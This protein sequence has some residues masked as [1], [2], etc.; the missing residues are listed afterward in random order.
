MAGKLSMVKDGERS[1]KE[2]SKLSIKKVLIKQQPEN[3]RNVLLDGRFCE[4]GV[5]I[6]IVVL[7]F[8]G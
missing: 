2:F 5:V 8:P 1:L 6:K 4:L 3:S 7:W